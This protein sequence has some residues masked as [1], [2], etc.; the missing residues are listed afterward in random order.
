MGPVSRIGPGRGPRSQARARAPDPGDAH[1][2]PGCAGLLAL[3]CLASVVVSGPAQRPVALAF[4]G[5]VV[6]GELTRR[7]GA[8][9]REAAPLGAACAPAYAL[10]GDV[11]VQPAHHGVAQTVTAALAASLG[12]VPYVARGS[13]PVL[14]HLARRVLTVGFAK[15]A[16]HPAAVVRAA[17]GRGR[18]ARRRTAR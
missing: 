11:A 7:T 12:S 16:V 15:G 6:L 17:L 8:E 1:L 9:A 14:G 3:G 13:G 5:L 4:G 18:P 10:L 2:V